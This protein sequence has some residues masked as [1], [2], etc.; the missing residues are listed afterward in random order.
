MSASLVPEV[1]DEEVLERRP[2]FSLGS[3]RRWVPWL[4]AGLLVLSIVWGLFVIAP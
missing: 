3:L 1:S 2:L 4:V